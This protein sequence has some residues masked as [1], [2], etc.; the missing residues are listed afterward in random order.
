MSVKHFPR[1]N[2]LLLVNLLILVVIFCFV[3]NF[4]FS[5]GMRFRPSWREQNEYNSNDLIAHQAYLDR[6]PGPM[7]PSFQFQYLKITGKTS[8]V[9]ILMGFRATGQN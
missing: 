6:R 2:T 5:G 9:V 1:R 4:K 3:Q 8:L 7:S